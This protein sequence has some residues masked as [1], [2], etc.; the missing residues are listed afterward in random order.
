[1]V[2]PKI[3]WYFSPHNSPLALPPANKESSRLVTENSVIT[4]TF[5]IRLIS[6]ELSDLRFILQYNLVA[7]STISVVDGVEMRT[8]RKRRRKGLEEIS[9]LVVRA[10]PKRVPEE[11]LILRAFSWWRSTVSPR[12]L[13]NARPVRLRR[14]VL[15][16][17]TSTSAWADLL[18]Y[19]SETYLTEIS[20]HAP[21]GKIKAIRFR[22]GPMPQLPALRQKEDKESPPAKP[23][24]ELP[25][26]VARALVRIS[27]DRVR[28]AVARAAA[29]GLAKKQD[30]NTE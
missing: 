3:F 28:N 8:R 6:G 17:H 21:E 24:T 10:Y 26:V 20:K 27:N 13:N 29:A 15:T 4:N 5:A 30:K 14:G 9:D 22:V 7:L 12:V 18:Q 19:D 25:E 23:I 1:M 2:S 11:L 16:I